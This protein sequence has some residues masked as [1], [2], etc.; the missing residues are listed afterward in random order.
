MGGEDG[1]DFIRDLVQNFFDSNCEKLFFVAL[2]NEPVNSKLIE[3]LEKYDFQANI[4]ILLEISTYSFIYNSQFKKNWIKP[5]LQNFK[6]NDL[7]NLFFYVVKVK[8]GK[9]Q[10]IINRVDSKTLFQ[11]TLERFYFKFKLL[12]K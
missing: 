7:K 12:Q 6:K 2:S 5:M 1:L 3:L 10:M 8:K 11:L 4:D 9:K